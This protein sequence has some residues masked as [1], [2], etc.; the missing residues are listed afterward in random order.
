MG[1][2]VARRFPFTGVGV[3]EFLPNCQQQPSRIGGQP[4]GQFVVIH[5]FPILKLVV[6][7]KFTVL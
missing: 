1:S 4:R 7:A 6:L 2:L 5:A 3:G